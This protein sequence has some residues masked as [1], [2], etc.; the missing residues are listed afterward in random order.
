MDDGLKFSQ[1]EA[2]HI[3]GHL[4]L[5]V[6]GLHEWVFMNFGVHL[7]TMSLGFYGNDEAINIFTHN[8]PFIKENEVHLLSIAHFPLSSYKILRQCTFPS[9]VELGEYAA[10]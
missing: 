9:R 7:I 8:N 10:R 2:F 3:K 1:G 5:E 4:A 6:L